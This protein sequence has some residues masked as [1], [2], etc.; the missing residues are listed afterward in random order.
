MV[1][2]LHAR[3]SSPLIRGRDLRSLH[4]SLN[5]TAT[6]DGRPSTAWKNSS[7]PAI[8]RVTSRVS[9]WRN[10]LP[11]NVKKS[12]ELTRLTM[13]LGLANTARSTYQAD[14]PFD[15]LIQFLR[16]KYHCPRQVPKLRRGNFTRR[17]AN[18]RSTL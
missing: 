4:D 11:Q 14:A 1:E 3:T 13:T 18:Y 16:G 17:L 15:F 12:P 9:K 2:P 10:A 8:S 5:R 7:I 6:R